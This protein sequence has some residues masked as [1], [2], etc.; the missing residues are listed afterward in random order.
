MSEN[1]ELLDQ[2]RLAN[3]RVDA[4]KR[5]VADATAFAVSRDDAMT[6][7]HEVI[8]ETRNIGEIW[9]SCTPEERFTLL[10]YWVLDVVLVV[11]PLAG[12]NR[13]NHKAALVTL[14]TT[15]KSPYL[16]LLGG[17]RATIDVTAEESSSSTHSSASLETRASNAGISDTVPSRPSAQAACPRTSGSSSDSAESNAGTSL[18]AP[19]L[20]STTAALRF[21]PR[22]FARFIG[23]PLNAAEY[24]SRDIDSNHRAV[25]RE[26]CPS[27]DFREE[28]ASSVRDFENLPLYGQ[29]SWHTSHPYTISPIASRNPSGIAPR[30]SIVK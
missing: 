16:L 23:E 10:D 13:A 26:S 11:R 18:G 1:E 24:S 6:Q 5:L 28:N 3:R 15:P 7:L 30:S 9:E 20:P 12:M 19:V 22:S 8:N 25:A 17:D 4:A 2:L 21:N 29:T 27:S 14:R